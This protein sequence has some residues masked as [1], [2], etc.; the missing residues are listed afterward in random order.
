VLASLSVASVGTAHAELLAAKGAK[1]TVKVEYVYTAVGMKK[2]KYD[3]R[4]WKVNRSATVT[5]QF[6]AQKAQAL[7]QMRAMEAGQVA[8]MQSKQAAAV[9]AAKKMQPTMND[10]LKIVEKCGDTNEACIEKEIEAYGNKMEITPELMSAGKDID[11]V[12]KQDG[13]RYQVWRAVSQ[14]STYSVD[15]FYKGQTADPICMEKPGQRCR[16]EETRKGQ[17]SVT[18]PPGAKSVSPAFF[19]VDAQKKDIVLALPTP[20]GP[21]ACASVVKSDFPNESSG[22]SPCTAGLGQVSF[23]PM[24]VTIPGDF[25]QLSG[26]QELKSE[27]AEGEGGTLSVRWTI[28]VP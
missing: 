24:T 19:E 25:R 17:G 9:S 10:M 4:E 23:K 28:T 21:L 15:E 7:A 20:M 3:P 1:A 12:G 14:Q 13:P 8:D 27:G 18:P 5:A 11:K 6:E 2:D 26:S 22:S 16:R